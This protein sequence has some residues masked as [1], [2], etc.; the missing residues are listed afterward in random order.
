[1]LVAK[2]KYDSTRLSLSCCFA[3]LRRKQ[4]RKKEV[5]K[6]KATLL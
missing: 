4:E 6:V 2:S 3:E 5:K 1:M